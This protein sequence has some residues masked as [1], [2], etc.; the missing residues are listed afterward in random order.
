MA[1]FDWDGLTLFLF[2]LMRMAG[3]VLFNPFFGR[4][5]LPQSF[6]AGLSLVLALSVSYTYTG[7]AATPGTFLELAVGLLLELAMGYLVGLVVNLFLFVPSFAGHI[8]DEQMG[9]AMAQTYDPSFQGQATPAGNVLN[10]F[11]ILLFFTANGHQTLLRLMLDSGGVVPFGSAALGEAAAEK[12][13]GLFIDCVLLA[14][15]LCLPVLGAELMGQVGMGVLMKAIP[16]INV[17]A[18]NIELKVLI[19]M[20]M[21]FFLIAPF[22]EFLLEI[23]NTMLVEVERAIALAGGG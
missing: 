19:G 10:I 22:S 18:I 5:N 17:F 2:I 11:T 15:K 4:S 3:F 21:L 8:M 1:G 7:T 13:A 23:E 20:A 6:K 12:I 9:M 16:Q 14:V